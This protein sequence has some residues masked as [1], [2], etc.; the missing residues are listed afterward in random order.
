MD[1]SRQLGSG[2]TLLYAENGLNV[3]RKP[4]SI[5]GENHLALATNYGFQ[6]SSS[7]C[8][9]GSD[10]ILGRHVSGAIYFVA[11]NFP[12]ARASFVCRFR[13]WQE[14]LFGEC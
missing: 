1:C 7:F 8:Y 4:L 13:F 10:S 11:I 6:E 5:I 14:A 2:S 12:H 3:N 9:L